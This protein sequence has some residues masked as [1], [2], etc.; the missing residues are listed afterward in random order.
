M[1]KSRRAAVALL[2]ITALALAA[3]SSGGGDDESAGGATEFG[4]EASGALNAWGFENADDVG[5]SRLDFAAEQLPDVDVELDATAFD[6]QK[7]TTRIAGGDVPDVVQMDRRYVTT[8]AAQDLILP[9]DACY[10]AHDVDPDERFYPSVVDDVRYEDQVWGV[11]QFFQPV[12]ILLNK[13]VMDA[14][15]VTPDQ[16][17]TSQPDVLLGAI[18]KMYA[19]S[20]GVPTTLGFDPVATGQGGLWILGQGGQLIDDEGVPTLDDPSNVAGLELLQQITDAQGGFAKVKSFSDAFDTFGD[21]NQF[22][23]DQVGAQV[24]AQWYPNVLS[25]YADQVDIEAVPFLDQDGQPFSVASGQAFVI[26]AGAENPDAACA[27]MLEL[28]SQ[29]A[30]LAAG[31]ARADT[32]AEEGGLNTGLFTG[33]PEADQA[34]REQFVTETGDAGFDQVIATYYD[35]VDSGRTFGSSPAGQDIQNELN[36]AITATLLGDKTAEEALADAQTAAMRA[37]DNVTG[38]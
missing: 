2:P 23:T 33:S 9:L 1:R 15:G 11:P 6:A 34:I 3:C 22:V 26:P 12:A 38:G 24:N 25:D 36:N 17:D 28:T 4:T 30:W 37:Y 8:Y 18:E 16:I 10:S 29:D 21:A 20:G 5:Q 35:V 14:A 7:F 19:E 32:I 31:Q 27:W 13:R